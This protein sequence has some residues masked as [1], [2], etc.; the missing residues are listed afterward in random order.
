MTS[1][2]RPSCGHLLEER[3]EVLDRADFLFVDQDDGILEQHVHALG[4]GDEV[5]REVSTIELHA[6]D[7]LER[8]LER[9]AFFNRD[10][11][12]LAHLLHRFRDDA[13][14]RLVAVG[15]D[16]ADLRDHRARDVARRR[17]DVGDD[18][19]DSRFDAALEIHRVGAGRYLSQS[20]SVDCPREYG[21]RRRTVAGGV[22]G[23]AG[24]LDDHLRA[25][26]LERILE[27]DLFGDRDPI[28]GDRR[29]AK[30]GAQEDVASSR[31]QRDLHRIGELI[32]AA[33][34]HLP[35][36]LAV[37]NLFCH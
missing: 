20:L 35:R 32:H 25:H 21:R 12:V 23:L 31:P 2:G 9:L 15:R 24:G 14:D 27:V 7:D 33:Q 11:A 26:V 28:F 3:Q 22:G 37:H 18:R 10:D 17:L 4:V 29:R 8:R 5:R 16:G 13:P 1:S 19:V 36:L 30:A 6:L 34:H